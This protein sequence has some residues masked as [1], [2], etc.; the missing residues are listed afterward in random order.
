MLYSCVVLHARQVAS[1]TSENWPAVQFL[2]TVL[3][4]IVPEEV[5]FVPAAHTVQ[6]AQVDAAAVAE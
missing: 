2:Q 4:V 1:P 5:A 6:G 3:A